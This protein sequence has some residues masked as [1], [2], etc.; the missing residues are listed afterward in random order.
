MVDQVNG[1]AW[2]MS[3]IKVCCKNHDTGLQLGLRFWE[4]VGVGY[5]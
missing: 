1:E 2:L 3:M 5:W 4:A